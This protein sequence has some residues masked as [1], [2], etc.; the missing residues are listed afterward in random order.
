ML[1]HK[2]NIGYDIYMYIFIILKYEQFSLILPI[3]IIRLIVGRNQA[4]GTV[5]LN[6][7]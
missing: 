7:Q 3:G 4:K 2:D 6:T 5:K 1:I